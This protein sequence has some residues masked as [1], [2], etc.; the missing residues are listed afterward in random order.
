M[1]KCL[2]IYRSSHTYNKERHGVIM[3]INLDEINFRDL[4]NQFLLVK[5]IDRK[6]KRTIEEGGFRIRP[7]DNAMLVF[8]YIDRHAG[9]SFELLCAA[10]VYDDGEV[11]FEPSNEN[12]LFKFR[13]GSFEGE[14]IPFTNKSQLV[15]FMDKAQ[16]IVKGYKAPDSVLAIRAI[17]ELDPSRAPGFPDDIVVFFVK[18]GYRNE[19]IWCRTE[20]TDP[21]RRLIQMRMLNEPNASFGKHIGEIVDVTLIQMDDGELKAVAVL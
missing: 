8:S 16:M 6:T 1:I 7:D 14:I 5:N 18:E 19:G 17:R 4:D 21:E 12:V 2:L 10:Y 3:G 9:I 13:Y 11:V 20:G 15:P